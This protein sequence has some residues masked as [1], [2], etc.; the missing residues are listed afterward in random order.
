[1]RII[2]K[3]TKERPVRYISHLDVQRLF[4]R[5]L[6]RAELPI[7]YSSGFNPHPDLSFAM[8]LSLGYTSRGEYLDIKMAEDME[9]GVFAER[10]NS[11]LPV[12][13]KVMEAHMVSDHFPALTSKVE[14]AEYH[15]TV[16]EPVVDMEEACRRTLAAKS[17]PME[18]R[19]KKGV[20]EVDIRPMI[21]ELECAKQEIHAVLSCSS[22]ATLSPSLL[23]E[24]MAGTCRADI[25]RMELYAGKRTPLME[26]TDLK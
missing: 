23:L 18:K 12:G 3:F 7:A 2:A 11:V 25:E 26:L 20:R 6:R 4:Q 9:P 5:A 14:Q 16:L 17:L 10:L 13:I 22:S 8:A 24:S 1:M 15:I 21:I 19:G